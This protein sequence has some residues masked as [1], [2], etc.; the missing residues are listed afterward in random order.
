MK[1]VILMKMQWGFQPEISVIKGDKEID[2]V[3]E[4]HNVSVILCSGILITIPNAN[5][6][7][8]AQTFF[9]TY[10]QNFIDAFEQLAE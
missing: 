6:G 3:A 4:R 9:P 1:T 8:A 7:Y 2:E 5:G 10:D